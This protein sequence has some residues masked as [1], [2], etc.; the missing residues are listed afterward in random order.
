MATDLEVLRL[1]PLGAEL[2]PSECAVLAR[3][4]HFRTLADGELLLPEGARDPLV[5]VV[6]EGRV[7]VVKDSVHGRTV[8]HTLK[9]EDLIGELSFMDDEPRYGAL[10]ASGPTKVLSLSR[11]DF[12]TLVETEPRVVYKVMRSIMRVAHRVQRNLSRE[13]QEMQNYVYR[14]GAKL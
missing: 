4:V 10:I 2:A 5:H 11:A 8:L 13:L 7:Q 6:V 1:S 9:P 3:L 14:T 12:E